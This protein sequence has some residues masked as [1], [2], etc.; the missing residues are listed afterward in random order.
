M[1]D[2]VK[3]KTAQGHGNG[4][5][6]GHAY[7]QE[8]ATVHGIGDRTSGTGN[9]SSG[10]ARGT[11]REKRIP[12]LRG[13]AYDQFM[14]KAGVIVGYGFTAGIWWI[15]SFFTLEWLK[16]FGI[17]TEGLYWWMF[18]ITITILEV[19]LQP[20]TKHIGWGHMLWLCILAFDSYAT[21]EGM[22]AWAKPQ[23]WAALPWFWYWLVGIAIAL[24]PERIARSLWEELWR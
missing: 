22:S 4:P 23:E 12:R 2:V 18:P 9:P 24:L 7:G 21:A 6:P 8:P 14:H 10:I 5:A 15:G 19:G 11:T 3:N 1:E 16:T 17:A 13:D 20:K